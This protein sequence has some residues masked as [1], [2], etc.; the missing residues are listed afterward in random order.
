MH[1][2]RDILILMILMILMTGDDCCVCMYGEE[3]GLFHLLHNYY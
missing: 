2:H 3:I 1:A